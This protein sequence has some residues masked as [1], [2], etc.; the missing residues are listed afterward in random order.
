MTQ[1]RL[2]TRVLILLTLS[3]PLLFIGSSSYGQDEIPTEPERISEGQ[4]L[5]N[6]NCK[7]CHKVHEKLVG[8][9]LK[10]VYDRAPSIDWIVNFV[11][12]SSKVIASGDEYA[13]ALYE[14]YNKTQMT[15]FPSFSRDQIL[16][17]LAYIKDETEKGPAVAAVPADGAAVAAGGE[18][19][20][21]PSTYIN[22]IMIGLIIVLVLILV[23]LIL[24][25]TILQKYLNQKEDL[26]EDDKAIVNPT[27]SFDSLIKSKPFIFIVIFLF[28]AISFKVVI[29]NL[30][31]VGVQKGY[32][33][34]QPIAFS[35]KLHAGQYEIDCN[36]CHTGVRKSKSANIPS[37]N[38]CM[39]CH[40]AIKTESPEIQKIYAAIENDKPIE[41]VRI[42]NLPDLAYFNHSQHVQVGGIE[43]ETCHGEIK[44]MEVVQ[45]ASLL[46]MGW[47]IDCH[48]K[49]DVNTKGNDYYDKLVELHEQE[50]KEALKVED[51]GGLECSKCHY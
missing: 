40:S 7:T 50:S 37:P 27:F 38:I 14:E 44:E 20:G 25:T 41:W 35:H 13:N 10:D 9:A 33:P 16:S 32:A 12:N 45:Q 49:T 24:I 6:G 5:F 8:P 11:Q 51:I 47:C 15:A 26:D 22:A 43:C 2:F 23:V 30:Y 39:N 17:I 34:K 31:A 19:S 4:S 21:V 46:T 1:N 48:R 29:N 36:Y 28:A 3:L 18:G 42:H